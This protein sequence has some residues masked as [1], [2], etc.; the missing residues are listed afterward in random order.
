MSPTHARL[1][2]KMALLPLLGAL[3][4]AAGPP[5]TRVQA[6]KLGGDDQPAEVT[7]RKA[8]A[9]KAVNVLHGRVLDE[10][11]REPVAG[12]IVAVAAV[13]VGGIFWQGGNMVQAY[14]P[15]EKVL[16]FFSK[17]N[18]QQAGQ[19]T[20]DAEGRF[21]IRN[22][23]YGDYN[24]AAILP[25]KGLTLRE[26]VAFE[27]KTG[28]I[29]V[30]LAPLAD[31]PSRRTLT[32]RVLDHE[33]N[34]AA[35][36]K[37]AVADS[38]NGYLFCHAGEYVQASYFEPNNAKTWFQSQDGGGR[39]GQTTT[40]ADGRFSIDGLK[41]G[42]YNLLAVG[43]EA[44]VEIVES[45]ALADD[46][47]PLDIKLSPPIYVEGTIKG[48]KS[49]TGSQPRFGFLGLF[50]AGGW[51]TCELAAEGLPANVRF[52][53]S[54]MLADGAFPRVGPLPKAKKWTLTA[55]EFVARR[56]YVATLLTAPVSIEPGKTSKIEIDLTKGLELSGNVRGPEGE[57]LSGVSVLAK[58]TGETGW[59]IGAV[60][61]SHG[62]YTLRGLSEGE[63]LLEVLRHALR[64]APG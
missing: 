36:V 25:G 39:A 64:T 28:P 43:A 60:T 35:N 5:A 47:E 62:N 29:E 13:D 31:E 2:L 10:K 7:G 41:P 34:P 45:H 38:K 54:I 23:A 37:V 27:K 9:D 50:S 44:G 22:L 20:T 57:A 26:G 11:T 1:P 46:P 12:V 59:A 15:E 6:I 17:L 33:G 8:A 56:G 42:S 32:G 48:L 49:E 63:H 16:F 40:D 21:E 61:D 24:L 14:A 52:N 51:T 58:A 55:S 53:T 18:G 19:H 3:L 30:L 4:A